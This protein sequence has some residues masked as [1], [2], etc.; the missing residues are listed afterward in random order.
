MNAVV[1]ITLPDAVWEGVD[2]GAQALLDRWLVDE[3]AS[4]AA[5][6][7]VARA[8]LVK[9]TIDIVAPAAGVVQRVLVPA[10]ENFA[11]GQALAELR[12]G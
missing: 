11:R 2:A 9:A 3:G 5:G 7:T 4:V 6:D 1:S 8:V 10:G 12:P